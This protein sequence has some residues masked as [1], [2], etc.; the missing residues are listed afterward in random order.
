MRDYCWTNGYC[1][2]HLGAILASSELSAP[3]IV[4][5]FLVYPLNQGKIVSQN[6]RSFVRFEVSKITHK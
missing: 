1:H 5:G 6:V 4:Q 2:P 3:F